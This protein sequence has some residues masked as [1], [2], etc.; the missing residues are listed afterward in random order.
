M[1]WTPLSVACCTSEDGR[2]ALDVLI[3]EAL[4]RRKGHRIAEE[5]RLGVKGGGVGFNWRGML[6]EVCVLGR[7]GVLGMT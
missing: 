1:S 6:P 2:D 3:G 7:S 4:L 5:S